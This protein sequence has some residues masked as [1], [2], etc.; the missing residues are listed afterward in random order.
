MGH[1]D[2][3]KPWE[4]CLG[5]HISSATFD[6]APT[7]VQA[8]ILLSCLMPRHSGKVGFPDLNSAIKFEVQKFLD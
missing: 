7:E 6:L 8:I 1:G 3:W 2:H 4:Q 5:E